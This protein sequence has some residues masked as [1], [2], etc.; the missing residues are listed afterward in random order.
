MLKKLLFHFA[1]HLVR[2][3]IEEGQCKRGYL[4][5]QLHFNTNLFLLL[6]NKC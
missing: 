3:E 5:N 2:R 4:K 1:Y 6:K